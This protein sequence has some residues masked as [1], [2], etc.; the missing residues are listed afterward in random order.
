MKQ[1]D[2]RNFIIYF[3][4]RKALLCIVDCDILI[5][6]YV[7][8]IANVNYGAKSGIEVLSMSLTLSPAERLSKLMWYLCPYLVI[9]GKTEVGSSYSLALDIQICGVG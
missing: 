2:Q 3:T 8:N 4:T 1:L 6:I 9:L 5:F 7:S